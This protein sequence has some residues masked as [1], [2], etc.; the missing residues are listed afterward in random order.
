MLKMLKKIVWS[1]YGATF[2]LFVV[3]LLWGLSGIL[4]GGG[5]T[6]WLFSF[7]AIIPCTVFSFGIVLGFRNTQL[8][9][10]YP[11]VFGMFS[12]II[13]HVVFRYSAATSVFLRTNWFSYSPLVSFVFAFSGVVTGIIIRITYHKMSENAQLK[14]KRAAG[15]TLVIAGV[16]TLIHLVHALTLD[17]IIEYREITFSSPN[18]PIAMNG[19]RIAF[20]VDTHTLPGVH[21]REVVEELN[22]RQIDLLLLGGD[23]PSLDGAPWRSMEILSHTI[24]TD[25]IFG[26]EGNHDNYEELFE[27]KW[28]HGIIPLSNSGLHIRDNFFLAGVEDPCSRSPSIACAIEDSEPGDFVLLLSHDPDTTMKQGTTG[29]DLILSGH[30]HGGQMTFFGIWAP[31]FTFRSSITEYGQHFV[32]GWAESRDGVPVFVSNGT[33]DYLPRIFARPQVILI[34]LKHG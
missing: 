23:F 22:N 9:W 34:T 19:Y 30:T 4:G 2:I 31:Y 7:Y 27:A 28:A 15:I 10:L 11:V 13:V 25:G 26:V 29:I 20:I 14:L 12:R 5:H 17:R 24:T 3:I 18:V 32:S 1:C 33:G 8:K 6:Y 16:I 21:L